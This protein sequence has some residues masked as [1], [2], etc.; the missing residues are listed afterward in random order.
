MS[1]V[2]LVTGGAGFIGSAV[3]GEALAAGWRVRVL[4]SLR[5]DV[6]PAMGA[7]RPEIELVHGDV[8]D[9]DTVRRALAGVDAVCH[10][11]A[12]VGLGVGIGD[13]P[14]YVSSNSLGTAVLLAGMA[15]AG[16][17]RLVLA[18]SMVVYGEGL[19][20]DDDRP[21]QPPPRTRADL[22][23]RRF[24]PLSARTGAALKPISIREEQPCD[25]RNVYA[26]T[27]LEQELLARA[28]VQG[29]GRAAMLRY[30]NVYGPDMPQGTP[31]A[32]VASLFRS[33][34]ER[35]E[36]PRVFEDG[37]QRRDFIHVRDVARAN[38]AALDWTGTIEPET[39]RAFNVATG[40]PHTIGD[41]ADGLAAAF[42][43]RTPLRTGEFRLG[44]VRHITASADRIRAELGW[45]AEIGFDEGVREFARAPLRE[46]ATG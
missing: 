39:A 10:Q 20:L 19:Y 7:P 29:G 36:S 13:A 44:D 16:V 9:D 12:K 1:G 11:A 18:S 31:Y 28:W 35:G 3:V 33:A 37:N 42:G 30:H 40:V 34:L 4:D 24:E 25:P 46:K 14:D 15:D 2:L 21:V 38:L 32:G 5:P 45:T 17:Q 6:H 22:E 8:R 23:A 26:A 41:F 43:Q 27:K